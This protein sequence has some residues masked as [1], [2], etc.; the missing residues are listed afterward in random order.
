MGALVGG[1]MGR[2]VIGWVGRLVGELYCR[3]V[4]GA[5]WVCV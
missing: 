2:W 3:W 1:L 4:V 5:S